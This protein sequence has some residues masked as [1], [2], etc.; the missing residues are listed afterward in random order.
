MRQLVLT[1]IYDNLRTRVSHFHFAFSRTIR[2]R[3]GWRLHGASVVVLTAQASILPL[4]LT[5]P[6]TYRTHKHAYA[7][8]QRHKNKS[9][10]YFRQTNPEFKTTPNFSNSCRDIRY[11]LKWHW[12]IIALLWNFDHSTPHRNFYTRSRRKIFM[13]HCFRDKQSLITQLLRNWQLLIF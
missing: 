2:R 7:P 10:A 8:A 4:L 6:H 5:N 1:T 13:V 3:C 12:A 11:L 9:S